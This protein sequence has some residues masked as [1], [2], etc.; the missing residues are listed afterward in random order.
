MSIKPSGEP[1]LL[2][3][4]EWRF[5]EGAKHYQ[6]SNLGRVKS[7]P[8]LAMRYNPRWK[9][10]S[11]LPVSERILRQGKYYGKNR[12]GSRRERPAATTVAIDV[13][14]RTV[15]RYVHH[16]VLEAFV[17]PRPE[18]TEACHGD[19]NGTN[20]KLANLRWDTHAENIKDSVSHGTFWPKIRGRKAA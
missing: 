20:N 14:G 11:P 5:I 7:L 6:V 4:E 17:G 16:L 1:L 19:G 9:C 13:N 8:R 2:P 10:K 15:S 3:G 18:G 12:D